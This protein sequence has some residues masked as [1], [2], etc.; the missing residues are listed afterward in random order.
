MGEP[1]VDRE[2]A[3]VSVHGGQR[4]IPAAG[5]AMRESAV[6]LG[7]APQEA[8]RLRAATEAMA[9]EV[10]EQG[11][12]DVDTASFDVALVQRPG[13]IAVRIDDH[14]LPRDLELF[15][16]HAD[17]VLGRMLREGLADDLRFLCLGREGNRVELVKRVATGDVR[18]EL[19]IQE[20]H[21]HLATPPVPDDTPI[22]VRF[23]KAAEAAQLARCVYR[24][25]G[26]SYDA[27]WV[28]QPELVAERIERGVLRSCVG[29]A[30]DNEIVGHV[31]LSLTDP[32]A[33]VGESGQAV[34]DPRFRGHH[35]FTTM[36]RFLAEWATGAGMCGLFSE[37]TAAH[38]Y[39][40][41]ANLALGA[42]ETGLLLGYIPAAVDYREIDS[43]S[44]PQKRHA[45]TLF[46]LKTNAGP[47]RPV[48]A[49]AHHRDIIAR[50]LKEG[51]LLGT[52][53]E[54]SGG[55]ELASRTRLDVVVRRDHNQATIT[56]QTF[57]P[58]LVDAVHDCLRGLCLHHLDCIYVDLPLTHPA[59]QTLGGELEQLGFFFGGIFPNSSVGGDVL[60]LQYLNNVDA[61]QDDVE[62]A[63]DFGR[64][65]LDYV[66]ASK[67]P[68]C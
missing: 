63:S 45:V 46:Y 57:G 22:D 42:H 10:A 35:L 64:E 3:R 62:V 67:P 60:R 12:A 61:Q 6:A 44:E 24:S 37:A 25:Y 17:S 29:V 50:I 5:A 13:E 56:V 49:P 33:K 43:A 1:T 15:R 39:S 26:Y 59:S 51:G 2:V 58:D 47:S 28:Y 48:Y 38:P 40:Q 27:E 54:A 4:F 18:A 32:G 34:V 55:T 30:L 19:H 9:A 66:C 41:K 20:H 68:A 21:E 65:L 23:M 7:L 31:G 36:K 52:P 8:D 11:F 16:Q 14:G 53:A